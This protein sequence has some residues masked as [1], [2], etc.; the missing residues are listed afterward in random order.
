MRKNEKIEFRFLGMVLKAS[1]LTWKGVL[2]IISVLV[3]FSLL[4]FN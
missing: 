1:D 2:V 4:F 3:F